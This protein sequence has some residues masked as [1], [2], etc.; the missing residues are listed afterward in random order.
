MLTMTRIG[1]QFEAETAFAIAQE[2]GL[3]DIE[4]EYEENSEGWFEK[5]N[6]C[7]SIEEFP[8][9]TFIACGS[10][11]ICLLSPNNVIYKIDRPGQDNNGPEYANYSTMIVDTDNGWFGS[12]FRLPDCALY[13]YETNFIM[14]MEYISGP[15]AERGSDD[16]ADID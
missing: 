9:W 14:A 8:G 1:S 11:R 6:Q 7:F 15:Y 2:C 10:T 3:M 4:E 5:V 13:R 16:E 12:L